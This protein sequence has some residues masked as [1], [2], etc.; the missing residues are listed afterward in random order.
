MLVVR[1]MDENW[2]TGLVTGSDIAPIFEAWSAREE[3]KSRTE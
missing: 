1:P 2:R 3:Y